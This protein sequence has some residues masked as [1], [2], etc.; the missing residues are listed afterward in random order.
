M[1]AALVPIA[2]PD[3][4]NPTTVP[5]WSARIRV[6]MATTVE[7]IIHTGAV[8]TEC[9]AALEHG[10]F[11]D[12]VRGADISPRVAQML[13]AIAEHPVL[14]NASTHSQ[15]PAAYNTLYQ[16]SRLEPPELEA[17]LENGLVT[18][19]LTLAAARSIAPKGVDVHRGKAALTANEPTDDLV[20]LDSLSDLMKLSVMVVVL[21]DISPENLQISPTLGAVIAPDLEKAR[22]V[23]TA[24]IGKMKS[25]GVD[26]GA[27]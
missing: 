19:D 24:V 9:K 2:P 25:A 4:D 18:S 26:G 10:Q 11:E 12:A 5:E 22:E 6:S 1:T 17:A 14:A 3:I 27:A 7:T 16:L 15:L 21:E 20:P 8:L 13:M 23:L